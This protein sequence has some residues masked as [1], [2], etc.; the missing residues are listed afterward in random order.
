M[1]IVRSP[2]T[3]AAVHPAAVVVGAA[4]LVPEAAKLD[5]ELVGVALSSPHAAARTPTTQRSERNLG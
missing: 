3:R 5:D 2:P 1:P 4:A